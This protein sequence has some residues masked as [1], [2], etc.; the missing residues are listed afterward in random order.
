MARKSA[1]NGFLRI[2][3]KLRTMKTKMFLT[4]LIVFVSFFSFAQ[5]AKDMKTKQRDKIVGKWKL[6]GIYDDKNKDAGAD[7]TSIQAREF[8][9]EGRYTTRDGQNITIDSGSYRISESH[10]LLYLESKGRFAKGS[11]N[12]TTSNQ[13]TWKIS[14]QQHDTMNMGMSGPGTNNGKQIR[15]VFRRSGAESEMTKK[16]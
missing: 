11:K 13:E 7:S 2:P 10:G 14:F 6:E 9:I 5:N 8:D 15:Y 16:Q 3:V 1:G 4:G 12:P